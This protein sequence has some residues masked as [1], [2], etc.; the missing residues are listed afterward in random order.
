MFGE[1]MYMREFLRYETAQEYNDTLENPVKIQVGISHHILPAKP[2]A[3]NIVEVIDTIR[4]T[5]GTEDEHLDFDLES[6]LF[7]RHDEQRY[8][9]AIQDEQ[10]R[11]FIDYCKTQRL[12]LQEASE[13]IRGEMFRILQ[14][15]TDPDRGRHISEPMDYETIEVME[16]SYDDQIDPDNV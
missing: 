5:Q 2:K 16:L 1:S 3:K 14:S 12:S 4:L 8:N 9:P 13:Y 7:Y 15:I 10:I 11:T 6:G